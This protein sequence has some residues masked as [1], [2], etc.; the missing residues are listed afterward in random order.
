[1]KVKREACAPAG[2]DAPTAAC[3]ML[4][5]SALQIVL[6]MESAT[7]VTLWKIMVQKRLYGEPVNH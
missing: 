3:R 1:M 5:Y 7:L 6:T 2:V 4:I